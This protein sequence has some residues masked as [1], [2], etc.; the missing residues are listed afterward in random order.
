MEPW[1]LHNSYDRL[2]PR[3]IAESAGVERHL[4][5]MQKKIIANKYM[6]PI[7]PI[8]RR[9]FFRYL[10]SKHRISPVIAYIEYLIHLLYRRRITGGALRRMGL[11]LERGVNFLLGKDIDLYYLMCHWATHTL[12]D[13]T[14]KLLGNGR[15]R[16]QA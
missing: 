9:Q 1:K 12:A 11:R 2:I 5:G 4:F 16:I 10:K 15:Q 8:L 13:R 14:A 3:R 6:W 7:N